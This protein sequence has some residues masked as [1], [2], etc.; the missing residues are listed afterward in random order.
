MELKIYF[1]HYEKENISKLDYF[2]SKKKLLEDNRIPFLA[3]SLKQYLIPI[4]DQ[5]E[6]LVLN[7]G[8]FAFYVKE[9]RCARL[10]ELELTIPN[11]NKNDNFMELE[12]II[13]MFPDFIMYNISETVFGSVKQESE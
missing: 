10:W 12:D 7:E 13:R 2:N 9:V 1:H 6:E 5:L 11:V 8:V 3:E 4:G